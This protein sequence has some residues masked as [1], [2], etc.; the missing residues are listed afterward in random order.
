MEKFA[1]SVV[2]ASWDSVI[3]DVPGWPALQRIP[4]LDPLRGSA[5]QV[6]QLLDDSD[7]IAELFSALGH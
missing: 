7:S 3:L 4:L 5:A 1:N 6:K 2:A